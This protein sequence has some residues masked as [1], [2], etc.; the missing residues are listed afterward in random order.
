MK[1]GGKN[2]GKKLKGGAVSAETVGLWL[3]AAFVVALLV[4]MI[5]A[6]CTQGRP[7]RQIEVNY[8]EIDYMG[9]GGGECPAP[10]SSDVTPAAA[11]LLMNR[12]GSRADRGMVA[13]DHRRGAPGRHPVGMIDQRRSRVEVDG[14]EE[15]ES[16]TDATDALGNAE[17]PTMIF[18]HMDGCGFCDKA[19]PDFKELALENPGVRLVSLNAR[20][21]QKL[22][23]D[24]KIDGFPAFLT[25]FGQQRVM[26]GYKPKATMARI[27]VGAHSQPASYGSFR[28]NVSR[29]VRPTA[30]RRGLAATGRVEE[31]AS[32]DEAHA[33]L[34]DDAT[35]TIVLI[36]MDGCGYCD[37]AKPDFNELAAE[38][39]GVRLATLNARNG[40]RLAG[41]NQIN[42]FPAFISN[43]GPAPERVTMGYK[44]KAVMSRALS[45]AAAG[46]AR[47]AVPASARASRIVVSP[48]LH[49][50][51]AA[52]AAAA[53][54]PA[55]GAEVT[56]AEAVALLARTSSERVLV[57]VF[58]TWCGYCKKMKPVFDAAVA[59]FPNTKM[60]RVDADKAPGLVAAHKITGYPSFLRNFGG[61][62]GGGG[63]G[64][65]LASAS[66]RARGS[67]V[68]KDVGYKSAE[69]FKAILASV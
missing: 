36:Y 3:M 9:G 39:P 19:K 58:A 30:S 57:F 62:G 27:I 33:A 61:G 26:M 59:L 4:L 38:H 44:P 46:A 31:L 2:G 34:A 35:P 51:R 48:V 68:T 60:V 69:D 11:P 12:N 22:A 47:G 17:I 37:K 7:A 40:R 43:F 32:D 64:G 53:A 10:A 50:P 5:V 52:A 63:G 67:P 65:A 25:N 8:V 45:A 41:E 24:N 14:V 54:G 29:G 18:I 42:G 21:A 28:A 20:K 23:T 13:S 66:G 6:A 15:L 49:A 56:E 1:K 16:E 55:S